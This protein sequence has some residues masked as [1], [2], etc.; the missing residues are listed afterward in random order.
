MLCLVHRVCAAE[1]TWRAPGATWWLAQHL[2]CKMRAII[3]DKKYHLS[4]TLLHVV[5]RT[6]FVTLTRI[7]HAPRSSAVWSL[8]SGSEPCSGSSDPRAPPPPA[9]CRLLTPMAEPNDELWRFGSEASDATTGSCWAHCS[10]DDE[11]GAVGEGCAIG[12]AAHDFKSTCV[13]DVSPVDVFFRLPS[14]I[15]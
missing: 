1:E 8:K 3:D 7:Q 4:I 6:V 2:V 12:D 10:G 9:A 14:M 15:A 13:D 5:D 11:C